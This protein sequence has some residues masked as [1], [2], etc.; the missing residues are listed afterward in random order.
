MIKL[1]TSIWIFFLLITNS[2]ADSL[3]SFPMTIYGTITGVGIGTKISFYDG[4]NSLLT[5]Y[6]TTREWWYGYD[7]TIAGTSPTFSGFTGTLRMSV[8]YQSKIYTL[9]SIT[10]STIGCPNSNNITFISNA[11]RYDLV[12]VTP[13]MITAPSGWW[14]GGGWGGGGWSSLNIS[15]ATQVTTTTSNT[16]TTLSGVTQSGTTSVIVSKDTTS[17]LVTESTSKNPISIT[18]QEIKKTKILTLETTF[19]KGTNLVI[20]KL[21]PNWR[22]IKTGT[23]HVLPNGKVRLNIKIAGK[24]IF[25]QK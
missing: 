16:G 19:K 13:V 1:L 3:P 24:Y 17:K 5:T 21:L 8:E 18:I 15:T 6:I 2:F 14:W 4:N 25:I 23:T 12:V 10:G 7:S 20:Y 22:Q 9:S 11:C